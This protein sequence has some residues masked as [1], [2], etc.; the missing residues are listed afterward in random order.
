MIERNDI[1]YGS[2]YD[3]NG[4]KLTYKN[5][6]GYWNEST[7]DS[8]GNKL[9]FKN[10]DGLWAEW[11]YD[12]NGNELTY[13]DSNGFW[14]ENTYDSNGNRLTYKNSNGFWEEWTYDS[15]GNLLTLKDSDGEDIK[16]D[17]NPKDSFNDTI[18]RESVSN[19][20]HYLEVFP[21]ILDSDKH[22]IAK[23]I[24]TIKNILGDE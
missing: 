5:S 2:T 7:Y 4:N 22:E 16:Y 6:D 12:S 9:T 10:Y 14:T 8:N 13:K 20:L 24:K 17:S 23:T 21:I 1:P 3:S 19:L 18:L 15:N 11:T